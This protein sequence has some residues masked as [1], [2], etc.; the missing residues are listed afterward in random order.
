MKK[1]II[2]MMLG[3]AALTACQRM[4]EAPRQE[5]GPM[6][7][8][9]TVRA[10]KEATKAL[11]LV[12][13]KTLNTYWKAG[14]KVNVYL[15]DQ[16]VGFLEVTP[17]EGEKPT[18]ATLSGPLSLSS[19]ISVGDEL[20]L[21]FPRR[22]DYAW[23][24]EGQ[25][26]LLTGTG[27]IEECFDYA[28]A[29]V[30]VEEKD[31]AHGTFKTTGASFRNQQSIYRFGFSYGGNALPVKTMILSSAE[32]QLATSCN[33]ATREAVTGALT[34]VRPTAGTDLTYVAI[35]NGN[36]TQD[37]TFNFTIYDE[38]GVTYE[39]SKAIPAAALSRGFVGARNITTTRLDAELSTAETTTVL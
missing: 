36:T 1:T 33:I 28:L 32:G 30:T 9:L 20:N 12:E 26:G 18:T 10:D 34:V 38:D 35:R 25:N 24:Y 17:D 6:T 8:T 23:T 21:L 3:A 37:D 5:E 13:D 29:T 27:S 4:E 19:L 31:A 7:W 2:L 15:A 11:D 22:A 14:E 39:G 16:Y